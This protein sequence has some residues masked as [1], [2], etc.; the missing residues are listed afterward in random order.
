MK[1]INAIIQAYEQAEQEGKK[2]AL[3][4][5]VHLEGPLTEDR[6]QECW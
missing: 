2:S 1:E 3:V 4:T 6:A 5:V